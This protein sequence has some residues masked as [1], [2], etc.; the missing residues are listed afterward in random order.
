MTVR[1]TIGVLLAL[2]ALLGAA[3]APAKAAD[4][5]QSDNLKHI[6]NFAYDG[7]GELAAQGR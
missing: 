6:A 5:V 7:G 2:G 1:K 4:P 3:I